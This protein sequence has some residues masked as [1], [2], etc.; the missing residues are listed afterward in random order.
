[1]RLLSFL[2]ISALSLAACASNGTVGVWLTT[3]D[4]KALL[5]RQSDLA[6][7][8]K[9]ELAAD[10]RIDASQR[11]QK[12][13]GF[14]AAITDASAHLIRTKLDNAQ[15]KMLM[16]E[17]FGP[18]PGLN[19]SFTRIVIGASDFSSAHYTYDDIDVGETDPNL[20]RFSIDAARLE[21]LPTVYEALNANA[22]LTVMASPWS[23]PAW[24]KTTGS[25]IRGTLRDEAYAPFALYLRRTV[26]EFAA[27]GV[28]I[29]YVSIQNEPD[30]EPANYPG[31]RLSPG[32]RARFVGEFLGPEFERAGLDAEIL[33]WDHNWDQPYQPMSVLTDEKAV[34][35]IAGV[36]WH[37]YN[38]DVSAQSHVRALYPD[39]DVFFTECSGGRWSDPWPDAW[40]WILQNIVIGTSNNWSRGAMMWNLALDE[41][42]GPHLGG[43]G[44]CRGVVTIDSKT[45]AVTRNPEYY[46]LGHAS[47]FVKKGA[48]WIK[49]STARADLASVAFIN[50]DGKRVLIVLNTGEKHADFTVSE[51][52][53]SFGYQLGPGA[54]ATFVWRRTG[55]LECAVMKFG[56]SFTNFC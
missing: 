40:I 7:H 23:A 54:A 19:F 30:F 43:C 46:A 16:D 48:Y 17:L 41:T 45:G 12:M 52:A 34:A 37:C 47:R 15:R 42:D 35:H 3:P 39:K 49:S 24:M 18:S 21:L 9:P 5:A 11:R 38:G 36:A 55:R 25:L 22:D 2:F 31:M 44:D 50:P 32:Q 4:Q 20:E 27:A 53:K 28:P 51:K 10:I 29:K 33:E 56:P 8:E 26:E 14:G 13:V 1:M 6:F